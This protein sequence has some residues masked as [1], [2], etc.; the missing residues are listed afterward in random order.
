VKVFALG[1]R[2]GWGLADQAFSSLTN[3][4]VGLLIARTVGPAD[5]GAFSLAFAL[6]N[7]AGDDERQLSTQHDQLTR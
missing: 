3:F 7:V 2:A 1:R 6:Y 4:A 5:F